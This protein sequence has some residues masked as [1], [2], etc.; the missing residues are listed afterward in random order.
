MRFTDSGLL[1]GTMI[2]ARTA[3]SE[4]ARG[5]KELE[6]KGVGI[7]MSMVGYGML[8]SPAIGGLTR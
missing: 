3:I 7:I 6:S 1:N 4:L 8:M 2:V 5:D